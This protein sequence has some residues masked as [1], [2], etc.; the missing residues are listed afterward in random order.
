MYNKYNVK[1]YHHQHKISHPF[2]THT[3]SYVHCA[4]TP[5]SY[6]HSNMSLH[7]GS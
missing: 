3:H 7:I 4:P 6:K 2:T 5:I 1:I